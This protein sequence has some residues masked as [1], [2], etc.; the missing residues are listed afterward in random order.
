M[1]LVTVSR[2]GT[3]TAGVLTDKGVAVVDGYADVGAILADGEPGQR[4]ARAATSA[5]FPLDEATLL[6]PVL[7]PGGIICVGLNFASHIKEMGRELPVAPTIF[8]KLARA[9]TDPYAPI[10]MPAESDQLDYEGELC[11]VI[12]TQGRHIAADDAW[13]HVGGL[14]IMNDITVRD[15]Q[16]RTTQW[17]AGKTW[18]R[19]TPIGP[20]LVTPDEAGDLSELELVVRVDGDERQRAKLN[21]L[22]FGVPELVEEISRIVTLHPGDLIATGTPGGVG[23]AMDPPG[24]LAVGSEVEVEITGLGALRNR[25]RAPS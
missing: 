14:T 2:N 13:Q 4:A 3:P 19:S 25:V 5:D 8:A 16:R 12:G 1:K 11:V 20:Y 24:F 18:E 6:R 15:F 22:V 10:P 21:D 9:L 17:L 7:S 23:H